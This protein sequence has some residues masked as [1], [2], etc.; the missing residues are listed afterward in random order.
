M[1]KSPKKCQII[2]LMPIFSNN[3]G[4]GGDPKIM[5]TFESCFSRCFFWHLAKSDQTNGYG[6]INCQGNSGAES[7]KLFF[8]SHFFIVLSIKNVPCLVLPKY[9]FIFFYIKKDIDK[10]DLLFKLLLYTQ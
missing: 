8:S 10:I 3:G 4:G 7:L 9:T 5:D 2:F 1:K 6:D